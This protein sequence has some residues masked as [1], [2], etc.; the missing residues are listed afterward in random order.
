MYGG[1]QIQI[2]CLHASDS[3]ECYI[4]S[5]IVCVSKFSIDSLILHC[6]H[7]PVSYSK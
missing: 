7:L 6:M 3:L 2:F 5:K 1:T 4:K